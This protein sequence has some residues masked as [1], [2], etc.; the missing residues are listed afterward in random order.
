MIKKPSSVVLSRLRVGDDIRGL[1][2][3][4]VGYVYD[5][6]CYRGYCV[7]V[8]TI[9]CLSFAGI[10]HPVGRS[11]LLTTEKMRNSS[12]SFPHQLKSRALVLVSCCTR[13]HDPACSLDASAYVEILPA[14]VVSRDYRHK[15]ESREKPVVFQILRR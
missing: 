7:P 5:V 1:Y 13:C 9:P 4:F 11:L 15:D 8:S 3:T 10:R 14:R 6:R 2:C 12:A